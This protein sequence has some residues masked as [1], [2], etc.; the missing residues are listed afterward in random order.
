MSFRAAKNCLVKNLNMFDEQT[1]PE[2]YNFYD[3]LIN[4]VEGMERLES[5]VRLLES[6]LRQMRSRS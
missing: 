1:D 2:K 4:I 5:Q 3:G 6:E